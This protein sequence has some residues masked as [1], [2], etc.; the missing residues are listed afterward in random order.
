MV[1]QH[2]KQPPSFSFIRNKVRKKIFQDWI[3]ETGFQIK[4]SQKE[5]EDFVTRKGKIRNCCPLCN[6]VNVKSLNVENNDWKCNKHGCNHEF[7]TPNQTLY[8]HP[9]SNN[10]SWNYLTHL[11]DLKYKRV[12]NN[13][14]EENLEELNRKALIITLDFSIQYLTLKDTVTTCKKCAYQEDVWVHFIPKSLE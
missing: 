14:F 13:F 2:T 4:P 11:E 1:L 12:W 10:Q 8:F 3:S 9:N 6:S 7:G 5:I